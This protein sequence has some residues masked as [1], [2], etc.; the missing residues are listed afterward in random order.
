MGGRD[1]DLAADLLLWTLRPDLCPGAIRERRTRGRP[2]DRGN[3]PLVVIELRYARL[4][5]GLLHTK[6]SGKEIEHGFVVA[7]IEH[8][9]LL[10]HE[11]VR[12]N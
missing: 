10:I 2:R 6:K 5:A 4:G 12:H 9:N 7:E 1:V 8:E 3:D 11:H